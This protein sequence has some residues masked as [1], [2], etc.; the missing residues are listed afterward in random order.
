[1]PSVTFDA[2]QRL[3]RNKESGSLF[4]HKALAIVFRAKMLEG[5]K[6]AGLK[7]PEYYP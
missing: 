2:K 5:I 1:M 3:W 6:P 7:L 4:N